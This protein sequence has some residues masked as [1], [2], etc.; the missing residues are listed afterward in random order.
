MKKNELEL[1][2]DI[3]NFSKFEITNEDGSRLYSGTFLKI[4]EVSMGYDFLLDSPMWIN[5]IDADG[6]NCYLSINQL[7]RILL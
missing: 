7:V 2:G 1:F 3:P 4:E 5:C 6:L